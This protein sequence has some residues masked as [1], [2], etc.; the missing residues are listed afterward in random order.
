MTTRNTLL[1]AAAAVAIST[2]ALAKSATPF[3]RLI[4]QIIAQLEQQSE[5]DQRIIAQTIQLRESLQKAEIE[6]AARQFPI[7]RT[8]ALGRD[9]LVAANEMIAS[10]Q[11]TKLIFDSFL[12]TS[13]E[14]QEQLLQQAIDGPAATR[15][16]TSRLS[17]QTKAR[18][19]VLKD[20]RRDVESLRKFP[21]S[22]ERLSFLVENVQLIAN[23]V[24]ERGAAGAP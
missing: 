21:T 4:S 1:I 6:R 5:S 19:A 2:L 22:K 8:N 7:T 20:L 10:P 9:T 23:A 11:R 17:A 24:K 12:R 15:L 3:E 16:T 13:L 14:H 18:Q